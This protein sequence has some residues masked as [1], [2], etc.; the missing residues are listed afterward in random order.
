MIKKNSQVGKALA[1][2]HQPDNGDQQNHSQ[3]GAYS[4]YRNG[5]VDVT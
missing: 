3:T 2:P 4:N 5:D 1:G